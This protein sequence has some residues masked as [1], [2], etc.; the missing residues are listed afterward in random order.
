MVYQCKTRSLSS[1]EWTENE[2][3]LDY[4]H[5]YKETE[6]EVYGWYLGIYISILKESINVF[7]KGNPGFI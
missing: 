7:E 1:S 4:F 2:I 3:D 5:S 6:N